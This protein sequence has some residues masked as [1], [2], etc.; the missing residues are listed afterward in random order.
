MASPGLYAQVACVWEA[1]ARKPGNVH[2]YRD[3]AD[4]GYVDFLLSA[5]AVAPVLDAAAGRPV[6]ATIL[7]GVRRT[8][9][10]AASNTN[11]GILLLLAPLA[12]VPPDVEL[13]AG[14][15]R[16]LDGLDV[17]DARAVYAAIRLAVP[18]GLSE[19]GLPLGLQLIG[20]A[21]DEATILRA[22]LAIEQAAA[23]THKPAN[24]WRA[25]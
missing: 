6:G 21:F 19:N 13:R 3:F 9:A 15:A 20:K 2:R 24:W 14:V 11:L 7:E 8:R 16:V 12:A 1:T 17:D 25:A 5:A 18:A 10:V 4:A 23:F 22:G